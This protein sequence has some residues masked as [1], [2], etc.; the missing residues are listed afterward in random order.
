MI[1]VGFYAE[2]ELSSKANIYQ[3]SYATFPGDLLSKFLKPPIVLV[4]AD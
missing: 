1:C 3:R 2:L 4:N